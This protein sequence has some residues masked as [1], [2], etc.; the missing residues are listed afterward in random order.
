MR[1]VVFTGEGD[2]S[3]VEVQDRP[4][5]V[6]G[7]EDICVQVAFAGLNPADLLQRE[8]KYPPPPGAPQDVPG[9]EVAGTVIGTGDRV[10]SVAP[11]DRVFGIVGGGGLADCVAAHE[12]CIVP[13]PDGLDE[14]QAAAAPE[15]FIT[16]H[17]ALF[18]Q[19]ALQPGE[20]VLVTGAS[21][22]VGTAALQLAALAGARALGLVRSERAAVLVS[23]L[24]AT[25]VRLE[26]LPSGVGNV[27]VI[28]ELVGGSTLAEALPSVAPRGRVMVVSTAGGAS[29]DLPL[30]LLMTRRARITGTVLR[31][32]PLE[33]KALAVQ[34]FGRS[35]V[36]HLASGR[37]RA[38]VDSVFPVDQV[39]R[40]FD[41]LSEMGKAGRIL[42]AF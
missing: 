24:G 19:A 21:G 42:V 15:A 3:V 14:K 39:Y 35:V 33:E 29:I 25:P 17:D 16:A 36:P 22:G 11:G 6:L 5:P 28:L 23:E 2:N 37:A 12:R 32:R 41:R 26:E 13:V 1:T 38:L 9:L 7:R 34:A 18:T 31:S 27:D 40:A 10:S 20:T 30:G 4:T 8:G